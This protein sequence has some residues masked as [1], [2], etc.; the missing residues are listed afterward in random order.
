MQKYG[1]I[2]LIIGLT[3]AAVYLTNGDFEQELTV[4][5]TQQ[6]QGMNSSDTVDRATF[7]Q[8]DADY[9]ARVKKYDAS[10]GK[11]LQTVNVP[12]TDLEFSVNAKLDAYEYNSATLYW[13]SA[14]VNLAYLDNDNSLLGQTRICYKTPH[15][16]YT[17]T[18]KFH[19]IVVTDNTKWFSYSF[20]IDDELANLPGVNPTSVAKIQVSLYDTTDGC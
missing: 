6:F 3:H 11:L 17:S 18:S 5:W 8:P 12:T 9:E 16:P 7:Y 13:A 19:M 4:G 20:N 10:Y 1:V 14:S 15:C 2:V